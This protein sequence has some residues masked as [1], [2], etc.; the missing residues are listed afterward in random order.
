[1]WLL[2]CDSNDVSA[3]WA[4][5]GLKRRGLEPFEV[6]SPDSLAYE[7]GWEHR[8]EEGRVSTDV[9]LLGGRRISEGEISGVLN[10]LSV[11]HP[12]SLN[13]IQPSDRYYVT[14]ELQAFFLSWLHGLP[15]PVINRPTSLGLSGR[16]RHVSEWIWMASKAGVPNQGYR[17]SSQDPPLQWDVSVRL[18]AADMPVVSVVVLAGSVT[19][20]DTPPHIKQGCLKMSELSGAALLGLDFA[21]TADESWVFAGVSTMPDLRLGGEPLLDALASALKAESRGEK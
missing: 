4:C 1:M 18:A 21:V 3:L 19:G 8:I 9:T 7:I 14:H 10:R 17:Q 2:T 16:L 15:A 5:E 12:S 20:P 6:L 13:L 11:I